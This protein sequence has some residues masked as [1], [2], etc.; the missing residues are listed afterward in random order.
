[1]LE[2]VFGPIVK[3]SEILWAGCYTISSLKLAMVGIYTKE[4]SK[5]YK[6]VLPPQLPPLPRAVYKPTTTAATEVFTF[7]IIS[8]KIY[9]RKKK[10][11]KINY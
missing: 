5:C 9:F 11:L 4:I 3:Y 6:S 10:Q 1:M 8:D 2:L 7:H